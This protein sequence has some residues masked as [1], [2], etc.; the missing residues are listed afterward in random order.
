MPRARAAPARV[1]HLAAHQAHRGVAHAVSSRGPGSPTLTAVRAANVIV[2]GH[3]SVQLRIGVGQAHQF[4][5]VGGGG[6]SRR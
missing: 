1:Q 3:L 4:D 5:L 2:G 6:G